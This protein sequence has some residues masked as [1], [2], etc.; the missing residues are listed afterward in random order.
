MEIHV[1]NQTAG[2]INY[3]EGSQVVSEGLHGSVITDDAARQAVSELR[4]ALSYMPLD[5]SR[6][7]EARA[8]VAE[9]DA[10]VRGPQPDKRRAAQA[11]KRLTDLLIG[12][13]S[14]ASAST[15]LIGPLQALASWLGT[16]GG[17][18]L[19]TLAP[20]AS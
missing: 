18:L 19:N 16:H 12:A 13:G 3:V 7:A 9:L 2:V 5:G 17:A 1:K 6:A 20:Y 11:L 14:L 10:T 4:R 15:A 8:Q